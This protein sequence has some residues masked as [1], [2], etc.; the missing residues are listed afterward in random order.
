[1]EALSS[2]WEPE[3]IVYYYSL[4]VRLD[5]SSPTKKEN[6]F[7]S[8]GYESI[9]CL[10]TIFQI[11]LPGFFYKKESVQ[12]QNFERAKAAFQKG[13]NSS[14]SSASSDRATNRV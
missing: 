6:S 12:K 13:L 4:L 9:N 11:K 14:T 8:S 5:K 1:M 7:V 10:L 3:H 2:S